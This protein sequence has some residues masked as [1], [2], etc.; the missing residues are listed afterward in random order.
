MNTSISKCIIVICAFWTL[1][2]FGAA[3]PAAKVELGKALFFDARLSKTGK[4]SCNS[5]HDVSGSGTDNKPVS[6]GVNGQKGARNAP[7][8]WNAMQYS[9]QF[10]DGRATTLEEQAKGP[11]INAVEMGM[12]NHDEVITA[13]SKVPG[14]KK[15]FEAAFGNPAITIDRTVEAIGAFERTLVTADSPV[16]RFNKGEKTA[17]NESAQRGLKLMTDVGCVACHS[18]KNYAGPELP[19]GTGFYMKFPTFPNAEYETKYGFSKDQGRYA[20]TKAESDMNMWRVQSLRNVEKTGPY[21]HNGAVAS[22][23]EAVRVMAK[24]Q[25]NRDLKDGEV[26][27]LVAF[28][29]GL[30]G[31]APVIHAPKLPK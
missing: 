8:V 25:L 14:Y 10:W 7:T 24:L 1:S 29:K 13:I 19:V 3:P 26:Q 11:M 22:L 16:D 5:C 18:G 2:A 27:D 6:L 28:L 17:L 12:A 21:F 23:D 31:T 20:V 30:T 4:V 9:V 15:L